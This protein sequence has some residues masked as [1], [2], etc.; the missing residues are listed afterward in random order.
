MMMAFSSIKTLG[1]FFL[2]DLTVPGRP[3]TEVGG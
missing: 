2:R 3:P 1:S